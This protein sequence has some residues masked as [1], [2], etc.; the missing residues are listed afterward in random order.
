MKRFWIATLFL[1]ALVPG[2]SSSPAGAQVHVDISIGGF[3]DELEPYGRWVECSYGDCWVPARISRDWQPYSNG[4]W[5]Y[6]DYGWTW[7]SDDPWGDDPYHYGTWVD[8][9]RWGWAWIP[10]TVW[11]PAWVT[12]TYSDSYIGWAPLPPSIVFGASGYSG[13]PIRLSPTLYVFVPTNRFIGSNIASVRLSR[14]RS[15]TILRQTT[16]I[17]RFG[18]SGGI[19]HNTA[20]PVE[21]IER[22][23]RTRISRREIREA[24]TAPRPVTE[25]T[26]GNRRQVS[27]VA[28]AREVRAALSS[29][30]QKKVD[31]APESGRRPAL[32]APPRKAPEVSRGKPE[33]STAPASRGKKAGVPGPAAAPRP[34]APAVHA[35]TGPAKNQ[36]QQLAPGKPAKPDKGAKEKKGKP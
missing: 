23:T 30:L 11:A 15:A 2:V 19:V 24:K 20:I 28:P 13:R 14:Q 3:Y 18:V 22:A 17:T 36:P 4:E 32:P 12:W 21:R 35:P 29:R 9:N 5:V 33:T 27:I 26:R 16:P 10:G 6:T 34:A 7:L 31:R 25:W 1:A 8:T